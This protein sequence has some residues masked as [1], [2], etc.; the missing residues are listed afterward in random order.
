[1]RKVFTIPG[2]PFPPI[3]AMAFSEGFINIYAERGTQE[4]LFLLFHE[5]AHHILKHQPRVAPATWVEEYEA[6]RLALD[7]L[8]LFVPYEEYWPWE[9]IV[10]DRFRSILEEWVEAGITQHGEV[11]AAVWCG[12]SVTLELVLADDMAC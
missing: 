3:Q 10:K 4:W 1:M 2:R 6:D 12:A 8:A 7:L 5:C 9:Q 11:E